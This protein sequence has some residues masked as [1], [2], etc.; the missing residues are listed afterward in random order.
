MISILFVAKN[1]VYKT[2]T[3]SVGEPLDYWDE[4][5]DAMRWPGGNSIVA[6]PPCRLFCQLRHMSTAPM[7][8]KR[9]AYFAV[10]KVRK[11]GG[12]LEHPAMTTLWK[13]SG[14]PTP[15]SSD[16]WG[17]SIAVNQWWFG[18][19]ARKTTWLYICGAESIPMIPLKIGEPEFTVSFD[20]G[21][22]KRGLTTYKQRSATP[23]A[24]AR[25]L[26]E[27]AERCKQPVTS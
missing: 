26:V 7:K 19:P 16:R 9:L 20:K 18:F 10:A 2:M 24:F 12:V 6:H 14:L 23:P 25:W 3:D 1:S 11:W 27:T 22:S 4:E 8:E 21:Q 5:R 15:G 13:E 17:V